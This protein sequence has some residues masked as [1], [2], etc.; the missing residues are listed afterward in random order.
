MS[1]SYMAQP[2]ALQQPAAPDSIRRPALDDPDTISI[3]I[4]WRRSRP[5]YSW[6]NVNG[7]P[8]GSYHPLQ[9]WPRPE[10]DRAA[11]ALRSVAG[12]YAP[13]VGEAGSAP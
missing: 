13:D 2:G 11:S 8:L 9:D 6:I 3:S 7:K 4:R 12:L 5:S 1:D 10:L